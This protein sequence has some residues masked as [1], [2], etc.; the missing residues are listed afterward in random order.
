MRETEQDRR[1]R[2]RF[3][4]K[5]ALYAGLALGLIFLLVPRGIPWNSTGMP[6][7]LMG[8]TLFTE[9][10][11]GTYTIVALLQMVVA[12]CYAFI[13]GGIAY[14]LRT[15]HA[16]LAGGAVG[17]GLYALNYVIFNFLLPDMPRSSEGNVAIAHLAFGLI[18]AGAYKGLA[19]PRVPRAA[20]TT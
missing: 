11:A 1:A 16:I 4:P 9:P 10:G 8:R 19:I 6:T 14:R 15:M 12:V 20:E 2:N 3:K 17:L 7:H 5:A 13:I 18:A